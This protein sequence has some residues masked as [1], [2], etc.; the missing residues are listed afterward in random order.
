MH[1][2]IVPLL[3]GAGLFMSAT[4][5]AQNPERW[6]LNASIQQA[7]Q[8]APEMKTANAN[9]GMQRGKLEAATAWPNPTIAIQADDKLGI[10]D[11]SGGYD[12]TQIAISQPLPFGRLG[13]QRKQAQANL[14]GAEAQRRQ[15]QLLLEYKVAQGFHM[16]Q[17]AQAKFDL[18]RQRLQQARRYQAH[19][20]KSASG[21]A[22]VRY[23]TPLERM[24]LDIVLQ[25]ATQAMAMAE[26]KYTEAASAFRALLHL[27]V[28]SKLQLPALTTVTAL[29]DFNVLQAA[30][31]DH[32]ALSANKQAVAA[33]EAGIAV[34]KSKRFNDPTLTLFREKDFLANR[35]D[36]VTGIMLSVQIPLWNRNNG[37]VTQ[38]R[39]AVL[40]AQ[41]ELELKQRQLS[42]RLHK[43]YL[44]LGHLVEQADHYR[45]HLLQPTERVMKLT[46]RGFASGALNIL[47]LIDANNTYFD[48][49]Q[50]Y[51]ELLEQSWLEL[52]DLRKSAGLSLLN[53]N[54]VM[55]AGEVK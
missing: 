37:R 41:A 20:R 21:D 51:F 16:L 39:Y 38:A 22:L 19:T 40:Q 28:D 34:A 15:Q 31:P 18:A 2:R 36:D 11:G 12:V 23:L 33:A 8:L 4:A 3:A 46:Q 35:R 52:A 1:K 48:T 49:Q 42:T 9:I 50:R 25:S 24:R 6:T 55:N 14:A 45:K 26:G 29:K 30:L 44:H 43:S 13:H 53:D 17:L 27:P 5:W 32:P 7:L 54:L 47:N 10:E